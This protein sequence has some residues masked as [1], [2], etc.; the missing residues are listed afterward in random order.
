FSTE[1]DGPRPQ[2]PRDIY[3]IEALQTVPLG[4]HKR[5]DGPRNDNRRSPQREPTATNSMYKKIS[6]Q[7]GI[8]SEGGAGKN[9]FYK[10]MSEMNYPADEQFRK[11][12]RI[13]MNRVERDK[14]M[15]MKKKEKDAKFI[16]IKDVSDDQFV[17][18]CSF[19]SAMNV[20]EENEEQPSLPSSYHKIEAFLNLPR[21]KNRWADA[22]GLDGSDVIPRRDEAI[23]RLMISNALQAASLLQQSTDSI[24]LSFEDYPPIF[25]PRKEEVKLKTIVIDGCAVMKQVNFKFEVPWNPTGGATD[26][27]KGNKLLVMKPLIELA[28]RF[29]LQGH[30]TVIIL[31]KYY[32]IPIFAGVRQ[33]VDNVAA[34]NAL[35]ETGIVLFIEE[36]T[37]EEMHQRLFDENKKREGT[38]VSTS[39]LER[40]IIKARKDKK[41]PESAMGERQEIS[42]DVRNEKKD[43]PIAEFTHKIT[44]F[45]YDNKLVLPL[46]MSTSNKIILH[47]DK[48][49]YHADN[50]V[51]KMEERRSNQMRMAEQKKILL[52]LQDLLDL[53]LR[54]LRG[55]MMHRRI[56]KE[57]EQNEIESKKIADAMAV[58]DLD[59]ETQRAFGGMDD[60]T[61]HLPNVTH[62]Q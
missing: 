62:F 22:T 8:Q 43:A 25:V 10:S 51:E 49:L 55:M 1:W 2:G 9:D 13:M 3:E 35:V 30:K 24:C 17:I 11:E 56:L 57:I 42:D 23:E 18:P 14:R 39:D 26:T 34:F 52:R 59:E 60:T 33:K 31:P 15:R 50:K 37:I 46:H 54:L 44:P 16:T 32:M 5:R 4:M 27:F 48:L 7:Q 61:S 29:I 47:F 21:P 12:S 20:K 45:F 6:E 41:Q 58:R 40:I 19:P 38:W 28:M 53:P 36:A